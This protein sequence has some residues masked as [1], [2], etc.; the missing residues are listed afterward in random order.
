VAGAVRGRAPSGRA[1]PSRDKEGVHPGRVSRVRNVATPAGVP[2][3]LASGKPTVRK[4]QLPSGNKMVQEAN[5]GGRKA[6]GTREMLTDSSVGPLR[7]TGRIRADAR[8]RKGAD[9]DQVSL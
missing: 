8:T 1:P 2:A 4:A 9:V 3:L 7:I 6:A 5:A